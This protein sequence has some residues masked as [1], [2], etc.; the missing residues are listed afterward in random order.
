MKLIDVPQSGKC[1]LT[2]TYPSRSGLVRRAWVVPSNPQTAS[3]L[4]VRNTLARM[5]HAFDGLTEAQ[6][7]AWNAAAAQVQTQP[8]LGQS[9]PMTGLQLFVRLNAN[10]LRVGEAQL[11]L[12]SNRPEF[13][14]NIVQALELTNTGGVPA[15]K[16]VTSGESD[17]FNL[18]WGCAPQNS[19]TRRPL[20]WRYLGELPEAQAGKA[21]LTAL[22]AAKFGTPVAGDR[23]FIASQQMESGWEDIKLQFTGLVPASS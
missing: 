17:S 4:E 14:P 22:Y 11:D 18:V 5:A 13:D 1:G 23:I 20:S 16:L 8:R 2:V 6:Q 19:G 3:Q 7:D 21:N 12:P 9:G 15:L 10:L